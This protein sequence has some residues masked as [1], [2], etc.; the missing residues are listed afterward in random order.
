[1]KIEIWSDFV[2]PFCYIGIR[3]LHD[4][5]A[6]FP[7]KDQIKIEYRSYQLDPTAEYIPD[8]DFHE[9]LSELKGI[10][11]DQT[12]E[13]NEQVRR[14]A[15]D[16]GLDFNFEEIKYTNTFIAHRVLQYA[17]SKGKGPELVEKFMHAYFTDAALLNDEHTLIKL[18][19]E[20][21]LDSLDVNE[22]IHSER[23]KIKV[24]ED[25]SVAAEIGIQGVPFYV[26]NEKYGISGVKSSDIFT[27]IL[28]KV[29]E[30]Q[31]KEPVLQGK[32]K[33]KTSYCTGESCEE[34]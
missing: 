10:P 19:N 16:V 20:V 14:Q 9:T 2:C 21:G 18:T 27:D 11:L 24:A 4:A 3:K 7:N 13:M 1:M 26:F 5:L 12:I 23:F 31:Q 22:V 32:T 25:I 15:L 30:E 17:I 6:D 29:W 28:S 33:A 34:Y 8:K